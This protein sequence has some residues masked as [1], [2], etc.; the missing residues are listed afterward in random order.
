MHFLKTKS[1]VQ[2]SGVGDLTKINVAPR[3][4]G[5]EL[6]PHGA[7]G[8]GN[9]VGGRVYSNAYTGKSVDMGS[10]RDSELTFSAWSPKGQFQ[11]LL[12]WQNFMSATEFC[13]RACTGVP[14]AKKW[15][16][17]IYE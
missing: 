12:E 15:C 5:G 2:I 11:H 4:E 3:D 10:Q 6:D 13:F 7:D 9:P 1:F 14:D 17:H 8:S 16:P